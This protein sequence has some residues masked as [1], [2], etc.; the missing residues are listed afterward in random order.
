MKKLIS[1]TLTLFT[2]L[3]FAECPSSLDAEKM[4]ECIMIE[5]SGKNY[6]DWLASYS[7]ESEGK[8]SEMV[9]SITGKDVRAMQPAA[10]KPQ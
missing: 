7:K 10:G 2:S 6:Q 8:Q 4:T 1:V 5:G 9:S 3:C